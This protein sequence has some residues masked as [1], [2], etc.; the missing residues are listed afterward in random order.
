MLGGT[1]LVVCLALA[2]AP[3]PA[4][5]A[6]EEAAAEDAKVPPVPGDRKAEARDR[7]EQLR[8]LWAEGRM[9]PGNTAPVMVVSG[10]HLYLLYGPYLCQFAVNGLTLEAKVNL[11]E[12]LIPEALRDAEAA[13]GGRERPQRRLGAPEGGAGANAP[14]Q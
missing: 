4:P 11:R 13:R 9:G 12:L 10:E 1:L 3:P 7:A 8:R 6:P 5:V 14:K 2:Q